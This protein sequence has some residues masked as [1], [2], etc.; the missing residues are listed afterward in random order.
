M[1]ANNDVKSAAVKCVAAIVKKVEKAQI[2]IIC[3]TLVKLVCSDQKDQA[4]LRDIYSIALKTLIDDVP[5]NMGTEVS[6]HLCSKLLA[7]IS[8]KTT[9]VKKECLAVM[10]QLLRRFGSKVAAEHEVIMSTV[11]KQLPLQ[12]NEHKSI[13]RA[14]ADTLGALALVCNDT[15]LDRLAT[16][17]LELLSSSQTKGS[18]SPGRKGGSKG[19]NNIAS[20]FLPLLNALTGTDAR[21][22]IHTLGT[23]A[24]TVGH[25]LGR[26]LPQLVP[27]FLD[28]I[29]VVDASAG[30]VE[31][32]AGPTEDEAAVQ[33][34][35]REYCFSG[36]E[37][38]VKCCPQEIS[39]FLQVTGDN[40]KS[41]LLVALAFVK[42]DP[43]YMGEDESMDQGSDDEDAGSGD[44]EQYSD[45]GSQFSDQEDEDDDD[46]SWKVR[47]AAIRVL[48]AII[49]THPELNAML[50]ETCMDTL[51]RRF[52]ER[53]E[54]VRADV[55]MCFTA[56]LESTRAPMVAAGSATV[57]AAAFADV[58]PSSL[59]ETGRQRSTVHFL[60][61]KLDDIVG[62]ACKQLQSSDKDVL[63]KGKTLELLLKLVEVLRGGFSDRL[64]ELVTAELIACFRNDKLSSLRLQQLQLLAL[65]IESH[66]A[67]VVQN[68][69]FD[70]LQTPLPKSQKLDVL[71][72]VIAC[73]KEEGYKNTATAIRT[74]GTIIT[75]LRPVQ[76]HIEI[77]GT[78]TGS[79]HFS[80]STGTGS[81]SNMDVDVATGT[82]T[83]SDVPA[84]LALVTRCAKSIYL[85]ILPRF[86][87]QDLD[88]EVKKA[89]I[90]AMS[91]V[92]SYAGDLDMADELRTTVDI[93]DNRLDN[94]ITRVAA[95]RALAQ[96][97]KSPLQLNLNSVLSTNCLQKISLFAKQQS[98]DVRITA[99]QTLNA[100]VQSESFKAESFT[101]ELTANILADAAPLVSPSDL[102]LA[103]L[104]LR[105]C[106]SLL[107]KLPA[108]KLQE[109]F[110][111]LLLKRA[112][113]LAASPVTQGN[114]LAALE[115][116]FRDLVFLNSMPQASFQPLF[117]ALYAGA[118][119]GA[120]TAVTPEMEGNLERL[121]VSSNGRHNGHG[122]GSNDNDDSDGNT[123]ASSRKQSGMNL[124]RCIAVIC[125]YATP[126]QK[127]IIATRLITDVTNNSSRIQLALLCIGELGKRT[128]LSVWA[129]N[130]TIEVSVM[131]KFTSLSTDTQIAAAFA[132]GNMAVG[133]M[134]RYI[135]VILNAL[136]SGN[137]RYLLLAALRELILVHSE[138]PNKGN[139]AEYIQQVVPAVLS[140]TASRE[141]QVRYVAAE[142]IGL[143]TFMDTAAMLPHLEVLFVAGD[144]GVPTATAAPETA[145]GEGENEED[146]EPGTGPI[147]WHT[148]WTLAI[149]L[150]FA[151]L[152]PLPQ[153]SPMP[154]VTVLSLYL[155]ALL[156]AAQIEVR[157]AAVTA[158][159]SVIHR[160]AGL[161]LAFSTNTLT[162]TL[163][164]DVFVP[165]LMKAM[166][167]QKKVVVDSGPFKIREDLGLPLRTQALSCLDMLID[168]L[169]E[170][171]NVSLVLPAI[172]VN[173]GDDLKVKEDTFY[174]TY[175]KAFVHTIVIKLCK[176][177]SGSMLG[178]L[179]SMLPML[180][181]TIDKKLGKD[182]T[183]T[184][185]ERQVELRRSVLRVVLQFRQIDGIQASAGFTEFN[186]NYIM[187]NAQWVSM[188]SQL[189]DEGSLADYTT[190]YTAN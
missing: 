122:H 39:P 182:A 27:L 43:N 125:Q 73:S 174:L 13:R 123:S 152:R 167:F 51:L 146:D 147:P 12:G 22:L 190:G 188:L 3:D 95:L 98:R 66:D 68:I 101:Q 115:E 67:S 6:K 86:E 29:G 81:G 65:L 143:C 87:A 48:R 18:R 118:E 130:A 111:S 54:Q 113:S 46:T 189:Q 103:H 55:L 144:S 19:S 83:G 168:T 97:A 128:D 8:S 169:P 88:Q 108:Q 28:C 61:E 106:I 74:L 127:E 109:S 150:K 177:S 35:V 20:T 72:V 50:H 135:P 114:S 164:L 21:T 99:M 31:S 84:D 176:L 138:S 59:K 170:K 155:P 16:L 33:D 76:F 91:Q 173:I 34:E 24:R 58:R 185:L 17:I 70:R 119:S 10:D 2:E 64:L 14:A 9:S 78:G 96:I 100:L 163:L 47:R 57:A 131:E 63:C 4:E 187:K 92:I 165:D 158:L 38:L 126:A 116:L 30:D 15:H 139:F 80:N 156:Q 179:E 52:R 36:L 181:A 60:Y 93:L 44:N 175:I 124:A 180:Q 117:E 186:D 23:I 75:K 25:R 40:N 145:E 69:I 149:A 160:N 105:L 26:H 129:G 82:A 89:A 133:N 141:S 148:R 45:A 107:H 157:K 85:A 121:A 136:N 161:L 1:D 112:L 110:E 5:S 62:C 142:C 171:V 32:D 166:V 90:F 77:S 154:M 102:H 53:A 172:R 104:T 159:N 132:L 140:S 183:P 137:H 37:C 151:C 178:G 120:A 42:Y 162:D 41:V 49:E 184:D 79:V 71:A 94:E 153:Q 7:G 56:L 11:L 134:A